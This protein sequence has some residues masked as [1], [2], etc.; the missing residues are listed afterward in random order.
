MEV[1]K[2]ENLLVL[3]SAMLYFAEKLLYLKSFTISKKINQLKACLS[4]LSTT[5]ILHKTR[6]R[7]AGCFSSLTCEHMCITVIP[8]TCNRTTQNRMGGVMVSVLASRAVDRGLYPQTCS[9]HDIQR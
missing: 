6:T 2:I 7:V 4:L 1:G 5:H 8:L 9:R 3:F